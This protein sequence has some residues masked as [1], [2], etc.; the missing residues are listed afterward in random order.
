MTEETA[1]LTYGQKGSL[2][3]ELRR[4]LIRLENEDNLSDEARDALTAASKALAR[5]R[6]DYANFASDW[7]PD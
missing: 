5:L 2:L 7:G 1:A 6:T 3:T 4:S